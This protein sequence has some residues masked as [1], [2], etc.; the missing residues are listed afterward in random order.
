[1]A[2]SILAT[3]NFGG[4]LAWCTVDILFS[5]IAASLP[6]LNAALPQRW[7]TPSNSTPQIRNIS[8]LRRGNQRSIRLS[9]LDV[10]FTRPDGT[11]DDD[12]ARSVTNE[13][14]EPLEAEII[15]QQRGLVEKDSFMR[16]TEMRW[17]E[18][19]DHTHTETKQTEPA[20]P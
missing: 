19:F 12:A 4:F 14:I 7:R 11:I 9:S 8:I 5:I 2:N 20:E 16:R 18:A 6:I 10:E 13:S 3:Y 15:R 1:M 17:D